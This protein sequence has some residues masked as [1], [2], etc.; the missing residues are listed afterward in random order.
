VAAFTAGIPLRQAL[1]KKLCAYSRS[2]HAARLSPVRARYVSE[3]LAEFRDAGADLPDAKRARLEALQGELAQLTQRFADNVL[4][5]T[6]AWQLVVKDERRLAGLPGHAKARAAADA[7]AKGLGSPERPAWRFTLHMPSLLPFMTYLD[8]GAL[9]VELWRAAASVGSA[10]PHD[11]APLMA[12][13]LALRAEKAALLGRVHF[14]D[15][16]LARR[17]AKSGSG[18]LGFIDGLRERCLPAFARECRELEASSAAETGTAA[19]RLA[20]WEVGYRA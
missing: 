8:D 3:T 2:P 1:W 7:A 20:P 17:M 10:A 5:A 19:A 9:R 6:N 12:T 18:A 14:A 4:D 15:L 13:I 11:N 16:V